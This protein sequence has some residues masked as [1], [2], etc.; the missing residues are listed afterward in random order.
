MSNMN[1]RNIIKS[2]ALLMTMLA[3]LTLAGC[4]GG[5]KTADID[6]TA[7]SE[8]MVFSS[9]NDM[10]IKPSD[11]DG[12]T[13]KITGQCAVYHEDSENKDYYALIMV[14]S[15]GCCTQVLEF[16][17]KDGE[18]GKG[19]VNDEEITINGTFS[20][21]KIGESNLCTLKDVTLA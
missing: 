13:V 18:S 15:T 7:M 2:L 12:K 3:M 8:T 16:D 17:L 21:E 10:L 6:L 1:T 19:F 4:S 14:D 11:Y 5:S 20:W 9:L